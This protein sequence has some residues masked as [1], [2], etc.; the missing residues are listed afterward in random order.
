MFSACRT[1]VL[2]MRF[3]TLIIVVVISFFACRSAA[4]RKALL[5]QPATCEAQ[6]KDLAGTWLATTDTYDMLAK[7][8]YPRDSVYVELKADSSFKAHLP[9]CLD[10]AN[11]GGMS[12][13]AIGTWKLRRVDGAWKLSMAFVPGRLFRYRTFTSFEILLKDSTLTL[14]REVGNPEKGEVLRFAKAR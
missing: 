13:D 7:K 4:D 6:V 11:K 8:K 9:D 2:L 1:L 10:A 12:W 3:S 14:V 5:G